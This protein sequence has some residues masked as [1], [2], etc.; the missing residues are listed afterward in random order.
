MPL[1]RSSYRYGDCL[2]GTD[3][4]KL[5][6]I[7]SMVI[8]H[9]GAYFFRDIP[10]FRLLGR[11]AA[12]IFFFL[13][14]Y[15]SSPRFDSSLFI[16]GSVL[17]FLN[18][19]IDHIFFVNIL[20]H[21]LIIRECIQRGLF[22]YFTPKYFYVFF[23]LAIIA[24]FFTASIIEYGCFAWPIAWCGYWYKK[25]KMDYLHLTLSLGVFLE[26]NRYLFSLL[27]V[28]ISMHAIL[29][30][31]VFLTWVLLQIDAQWIVYRSRVLLWSARNTLGIYVVH[32]SLFKLIFLYLKQ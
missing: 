9:L 5:I 25:N 21:F 32:L 16:W 20:V 13:I 8:D 17:T 2:N 15:Y 31:V 27:N 11:I 19:L 10:E 28:Q 23:I 24:G 22:D 1:F 14:G 6:G 26:V 3:V 7:V 29:A 4:L 12:P 30:E 18:Y